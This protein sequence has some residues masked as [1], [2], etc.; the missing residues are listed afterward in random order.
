MIKKNIT[1]FFV[2]NESGGTRKFVVSS[3]SLKVALFISSV[4]ILIF[5][6][7]F[8]DYMGLMFQALEN[9]RLE[10]ENLT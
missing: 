8:I 10:S 1:L 2:N 4:V 3:I 9:K 7:G 5:V 6:A